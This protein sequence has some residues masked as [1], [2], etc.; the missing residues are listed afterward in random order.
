M[1]QDMKSAVKKSEYL[2]H[3]LSLADAMLAALNEGDQGV[4]SQ[5]FDE[6]ERYMEQHHPE[7]GSAPEGVID[8]LLAK[9][10]EVVVA[11]TRYRQKMI[12]SGAQLKGVRDYQS[13]LPAPYS[14]GDWGSS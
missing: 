6:R 10:R 5:I 8:Q 9:D 12:E 3:L 2:Q 4:A 13:K 14:R 1:R 7:S 11:A